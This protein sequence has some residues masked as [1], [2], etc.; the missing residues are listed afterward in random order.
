MTGTDRPNRR[1]GH[2]VPSVDLHTDWS[3][4]LSPFPYFGAIT[5]PLRPRPIDMKKRP[6][7]VQSALLNA[8]VDVASEKGLGELTIQDV[9]ARA[10][11]SKGA[12]FHHYPSK[13]ALLDATFKFWLDAFDNEV[14]RELADDPITYGKFTRAYLHAI[15]SDCVGENAHAWSTFSLGALLEP[16]LAAEWRKWLDS[17]MAEFPE[18]ANDIA[19][20]AIRFAADGIWLNTFGNTPALRE[21][22]SA[23]ESLKAGALLDH[24]VRLTT[25]KESY[26]QTR[27][28][29]QQTP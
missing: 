3:V 8:T 14:R 22:S 10:G 21:S 4:L 26:F 27:V 29:A 18:E 17:K 24:L 9:T 5:S 23:A 6:L 1:Y 28:Q 7:E 12:L 2:V 25:A 16:S 13:R 20:L 15:A 19:L 11:V